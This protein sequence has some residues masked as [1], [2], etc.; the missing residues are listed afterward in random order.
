MS[1]HVT[2]KGRLEWITS[3]SRFSDYLSERG[4][5]EETTPDYY[6][7]PMELFCEEN[8]CIVL[9]HALYKI[10]R[11][12]DTNGGDV[13]YAAEDDDGISFVI[14][15]YNGGMDEYEALDEAFNTL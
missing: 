6:S 3:E 9:G 5:T 13:F 2:T 11:E 10:I 1:E 7:G 15:Y 4:Y 12:L 14:S 8:D